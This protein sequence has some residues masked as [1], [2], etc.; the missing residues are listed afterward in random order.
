MP[1][2]RRRLRP[3]RPQPRPLGRGTP[4]T[5]TAAPPGGTGSR[6]RGPLDVVAFAGVQVLL[7]S[8]FLAEPERNRGLV[9]VTAAGL[10]TAA[11]GTWWTARARA[12][13][14]SSGRYLPWLIVLALWA[15]VAGD[16][17][18]WRSADGSGR[19]AF[20]GVPDLGYALQSLALLGA[21]LL[22]MRRAARWAPDALVDGLMAVGPGLLVAAHLSIVPALA[23]MDSAAGVTLGLAYALVDMIGIVVAAWLLISQRRP[24]LGL[25]FFAAALL[26]W[27]VGDL[28]WAA[29][30]RAPDDV[31]G[32]PFDLVWAVAAAFAA[33]GLRFGVSPAGAARKLA[34]PTA[35]RLAVTG[36]VGCLGPVI[37]LLGAGRGADVPPLLIV[38]AAL[39]PALGAVVRSV[40][41]T[42]R[43]EAQASRDPLTGLANRTAF[44]DQ[45]AVLA[46]EENS[47]VIV[48]LLDLDD[49]K[50][51]NDTHGHGTGDAV[52]VVIARRL[53]ERLSV[54]VPGAMAARL[55]GDE[56]AVAVASSETEEDD[57][58]VDVRGGIRRSAAARKRRA[59]SWWSDDLEELVGVLG[60]V[61]TEPVQVGQRSF[62]V[63]G[64]AGVIVQEPEDAH[65]SAPSL[66]SDADVAMYEAK[67]ADR[68]AP[69]AVVVLRGEERRRARMLTHLR[70]ELGEPDLRQFSV[71][72]QPIVDAETAAI[73]S[74]EAL[75]RWDHPAAGPIGPSVFVALAEQTGAIHTLGRFALDTALSDLHMWG[76]GELTL[77]VNLS[78]AQLMDPGL[79]D[80]V[81]ALLRAHRIAPRRL[82]LEITESAL[83]DDLAAAAQAVEG[84]RALGVRIAIDDFGT[85][86]SSL[87]YL[88]R[89]QPDILKV[90][91]EFVQAAVN[92]PRTATVVAS[93][94][95]LADDLGLNTVAEGV[96]TERE[97]AV[98]QALGCRL[99]Q[100]Y[101]Y[102]EPLPA[103]RLPDLWIAAEAYE[104]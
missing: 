34:A 77:A 25:G 88:R 26:L 5:A 52:L 54:R 60:G 22:L 59:R 70:D 38:V 80:M 98:M 81:R 86:Y 49:F 56:F 3:R 71:H 91:R 67:N 51:I 101:A 14:R 41:L 103:S 1:E 66:L 15:G 11:W 78:P 64:S 12:N 96:E 46:A 75:L 79:P 65:S 36:A 44:L 97:V 29:H 92:E 13:G 61:F 90:D 87:R 82:T 102:S 35:R 7:L 76:L 16:L 95:D 72:Y 74:V 33:V 19:L 83:V 47:R 53:A 18:A 21:H 43:L 9:V 68:S 42:S 10:V 31:A 93:V 55:G 27:F 23:R 30:L 17:L 85:G 104:A 39:V 24:G 37:L 4:R 84:L 32:G 69:T 89:F 94:L 20:P 50:T 8:A 48:A 62:P 63:R 99:M 40:L 57:D 28:A 58:V 2:A 6:R 73:V 100:G 45:V